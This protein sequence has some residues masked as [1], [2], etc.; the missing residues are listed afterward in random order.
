[1]RR[2]AVAGPIATGALTA[3]SVQVNSDT[4]RR[5]L[6]K[7]HARGLLPGADAGTLDSIEDAKRWLNTLA[8]WGA[9][10][11]LPGAVLSG[12]V[13]AVEGWVKADAEG[14]AQAVKEQ[15]EARIRDLEKQ[16]SR[17]RVA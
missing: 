11:R 10:N 3:Q 7:R 12:T 17:P 14:Q 9:A 16:A 1:M 13:R 4:F 15:L 5:E 2:N 8:K 6:E